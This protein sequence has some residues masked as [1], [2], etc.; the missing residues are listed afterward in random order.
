MSF[1]MLKTGT[2]TNHQKTGMAEIDKRK[3]M[4]KNKTVSQLKVTDKAN[5]LIGIGPIYQKSIDH[6][7]GILGDY[8]EAKIMAAKEYLS[9]RLKF[10]KEEMKEFEI[11]DTQV[12]TG[13]ENTLYIA[14]TDNECIRDIRA[15][16]AECQDSSLWAVDF[17]PPQYFARYMALSR[18]ARDMRGKEKYLTI[19]IRFNQHDVELVT[20][21]KGTNDRY[22]VMPMDLIEVDGPL[23]KYDHNIKWRRKLD[24]PPRRHVSPN[25]GEVEVPS[26]RLEGQQTSS[27]AQTG[28]TTSGNDKARK[29]S[30]HDE[31]VSSSDDELP[32]CRNRMDEGIEAD[33]AI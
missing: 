14:L 26:L 5:K 15:R 31:S 8:M 4:K 16:M 32:S 17:I 12:S 29:I 13:S 33:E 21:R 3:Q 27:T 23:P 7:F 20:K 30:R 22:E 28:S 10:T 11:T 2:G 6:F 19:Q 25:R 9:V 18:I 24:R 1:M